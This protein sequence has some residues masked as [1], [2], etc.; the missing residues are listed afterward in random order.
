MRQC[1]APYHHQPY[2]PLCQLL[3]SILVL[4]PTS[5][6]QILIFRSLWSHRYVQ[7]KTPFRMLR[8]RANLPLYHLCQTRVLRKHVS[9]KYQQPAP[10]YANV[11]FTERIDLFPYPG[12]SVVCKEPSSMNKSYLFITAIPIK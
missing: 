7:S 2:V 6:T 4:W 8:L 5:S 11:T 12:I 9:P 10:G 3:L 1:T